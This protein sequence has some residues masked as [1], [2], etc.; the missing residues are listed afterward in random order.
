MSESVFDKFSSYGGVSSKFN[1][2]V[3]SISD[4]DMKNSSGVFICK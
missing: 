1:S 2:F 4:S 3:L